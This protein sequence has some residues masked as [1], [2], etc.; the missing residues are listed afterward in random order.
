MSPTVP[1]SVPLSVK[2]TGPTTGALRL[3]RLQPVDSVA[4]AAEDVPA[5]ARV[6][7]GEGPFTARDEIGR[8]HKVALRDLR[9]ITC[10]F[11]EG[12]GA[13]YYSRVVIFYG[14]VAL[15]RG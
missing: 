12:R 9:A 10:S 15:S 13:D 11:A 2:P 3:F 5:G 14:S 4:I 6:D 7:A 8:G 1:L